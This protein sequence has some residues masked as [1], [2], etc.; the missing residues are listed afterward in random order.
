VF[1]DALGR[2]LSPNAVTQAFYRTAKR[3]PLGT[4]SFHALRHTNATLMIGSGVDPRTAASMLGHSTPSITLSIYSH[5]IAGAQ[6]QAADAVQA[7]LQA[8]T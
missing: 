2:R 4:T 6:A 3:L 8:K 1:T 7:R 5:V